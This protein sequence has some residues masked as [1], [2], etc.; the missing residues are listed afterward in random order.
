V[1]VGTVAPV[2]MLVYG[3]P[4]TVPVVSVIT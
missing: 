3:L 4:A 1:L 2:T